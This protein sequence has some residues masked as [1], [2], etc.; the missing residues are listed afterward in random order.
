MPY[1]LYTCI[2]PVGRDPALGSCVPHCPS[3]AA[4]VMFLLFC[5]TLRSFTSSPR[6]AFVLR[7]HLFSRF[8]SGC[9]AGSRCH[10]LSL[11]S[12]SVRALSSMQASLLSANTWLRAGSRVPSRAMSCPLSG[13]NPHP[14][15]R[16]HAALPAPWASRLTL[17]SC[18][19]P[20]FTFPSPCLVLGPALLPSHTIYRT[21][22]LI[23]ILV[24]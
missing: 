6:V 18:P 11:I 8:R 4:T 20:G 15:F 7:A 10:S 19:P 9:R 5:L 21:L 22:P 1:S 12:L 16:T 23:T 13:L 17:P 14:S 2:S 3:H 24:L